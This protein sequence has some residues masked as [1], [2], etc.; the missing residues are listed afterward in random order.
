MGLRSS[1]KE[2]R[3][4]KVFSGIVMPYLSEGRANLTSFNPQGL[5]KDWNFVILPLSWKGEILAKN[6][7]DKNQLS[8]P[9]ENKTIY[10]YILLPQ[11]PKSFFNTSVSPVNINY[12]ADIVL[13]KFVN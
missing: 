5:P 3:G 13:L 11:A 7:R 10:S 9:G 4:G 1:E 12:V 2:W 6:A 8:I